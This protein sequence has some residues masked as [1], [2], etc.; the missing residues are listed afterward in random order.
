MPSS[1]SFDRQ[2]QKALQSQDFPPVPES[3]LNAWHPHRV[4]KR[5]KWIWIMPGLV[6]T[7]GVSIG[8]WLAPMGLSNAFQT[9]GAVFVGFWQ[10]LPESTM[11]W[12]FALLLA[13]VVIAFDSVRAA[14]GRLK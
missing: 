9:F 10:K 14:F 12:A 13:T 4:E 1:D 7:L 8:T 3:L 6:F 5:A 11:A 2:I